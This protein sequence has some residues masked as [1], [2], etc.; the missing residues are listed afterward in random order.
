MILLLNVDGLR[1]KTPTTMGCPGHSRWE[2]LTAAM[3]LAVSMAISLC[4][5]D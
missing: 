3:A 4:D 2:K 1:A 5:D